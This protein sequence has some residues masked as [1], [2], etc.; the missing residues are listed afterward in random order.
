MVLAPRGEAGGDQLGRRGVDRLLALADF[1]AQPRFGFGERQAGEPRVDE[2]ADLGQRG[3]AGPAVERD[4]AV[5][6][7][8]VGADQHRERARARSAARS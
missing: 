8:S 2:I 4:D 6:D 7:A 1:G 5:L 3:G